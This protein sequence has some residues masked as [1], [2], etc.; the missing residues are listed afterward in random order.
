VSWALLFPLGYLTGAL[1]GLMG[2]GGGIL[3]V[4]IFLELFAIEYP[5]EK[6]T[7]LA[8]GTSLAVVFL[9]SLAAL[10]AQLRFGKIDFPLIG[11][12]SMGGILGAI[13]GTLSAFE[14]EETLLRYLLA[15]L[16]TLIAIKMATASREIKAAKLNNIGALAQA[17]FGV[18]I[19]FFSSFFGVGGGIL[20]VPFLMRFC[21]KE[22]HEAMATST[23]L[24][25]FL[26]AASL[27]SYALLAPPTKL[28]YTI[29]YVN[30][31]AALITGAGAILGAK[32]GVKLARKIKAPRL[33]KGFATLLIFVAIRLIIKA[34]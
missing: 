24:I 32:E 6:T 17:T 25:V 1:A 22:P 9:A 12:I 21:K 33:L 18:G 20:A 4:P 15:G 7:Q 26:S 8:L 27:L 14:T 29:G 16:L 10:R 13:L 3:L 31:L 19:G 2:I 30:L 11:R 34:S 23:G 5:G 28:A